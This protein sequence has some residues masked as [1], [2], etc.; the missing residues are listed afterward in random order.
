MPKKNDA[1]EAG[2]DATAEQ[3]QK[4]A[5]ATNG[6]RNANVIEEGE[7]AAKL[8]YDIQGGL[9]SHTEGTVI[10]RLSLA[11]FTTLTQAGGHEVVEAGTDVGADA[12][13]ASLPI[14]G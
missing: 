1:P 10:R 12:V 4:V 6:D 13:D 2:A 5:E 9:G 8:K 14:G 7:L 11:A 3:A